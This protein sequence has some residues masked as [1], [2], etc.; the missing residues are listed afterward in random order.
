MFKAIML[1][2]IT[3]ER[4]QFFRLSAAGTVA[5]VLAPRAVLAAVPESPLA[6]GIYY[7]KEAQGRWNGK[8]G[9][10]LP[11]LE[12]GRSAEGVTVQV[13]TKHEMRGYDHY[14]VKHVLLDQKFQVLQE[15]LFNPQVDQAPMS[16]F[17][18]KSYS[19]PLYAV[20]LCNL[21]DAWLNVIEV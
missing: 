7:T 8:A 9:S 11:N 17:V 18:L 3:M 21:H 5:T 10:H 14:I 4:R 2:R 1:R 13:V 20:S 19:G 6:G 12:I 15:K 16:Q